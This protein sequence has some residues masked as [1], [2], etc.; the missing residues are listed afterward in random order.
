MYNSTV[1]ATGTKDTSLVNRIFGLDMQ[2]VVDVAIMG[3]A[4]FVL[5]LILSYLLFNPARELLQK[6]QDRIKEEMDSSAKDKKEAAQLKTNYEAKIKEA[7]KEVDEIL[8]EG[9]KKALKRENEIVDEAKVEASRIVDRAN[10]EIELNKSKMKDEVKQEMVAVAS[11][12]AGKIIAGN[13][14][15]TKQ[16]QLIDEALNEMGDETWQN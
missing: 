16:K 13:I 3:L 1:L 10:K 4:I 7:S 15:V 5:F 14:D 2:L 9:R 11:V 12:M 6:R 8:S